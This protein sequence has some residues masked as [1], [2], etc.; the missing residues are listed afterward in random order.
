MQI[1]I[2][3]SSR[4][5]ATAGQIC[6]RLEKNGLNCFIA[7]RDIRPG[8]EYAEEIVNGIDNSAAMVLLMSRNANGPMY[9]G[10]WR[11]PNPWNIF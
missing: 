10:R 5:A 1:F 4:D 8:K 2:S 6:D 11:F 7:P 9:C 3:H